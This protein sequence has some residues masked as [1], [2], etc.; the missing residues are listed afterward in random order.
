MQTKQSKDIKEKEESRSGWYFKFPYVHIKSKT[1][2]KVKIL[3]LESWKPLFKI[4][5]FFMYIY[6]HGYLI[7]C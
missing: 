3:I 1:Y 6:R 5:H 2:K 4:L 7:I